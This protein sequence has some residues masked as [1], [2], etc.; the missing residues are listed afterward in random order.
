MAEAS[1]DDFI[2]N[3][4]T[5]SFSTL[6]NTDATASNEPS[7][8]EGKIKLPKI[9]WKLIMEENSENDM[10]LKSIFEKQSKDETIDESKTGMAAMYL[11]PT[12][13]K[14]D[15][16][17]MFEGGLDSMM[18]EKTNVSLKPVQPDLIDL[19]SDDDRGF[20]DENGEN[21][22]QQ[23][24]E[25]FCSGENYEAIF[26]ADEEQV[27]QDHPVLE[28]QF[29]ESEEQDDSC[30]VSKFL[31]GSTHTAASWEEWYTSSDK[32][33][34]QKAFQ[35]AVFSKS[36]PLGSLTANDLI[37]RPS[38]GK[39][40]VSP[41]V[42]RQATPLIDQPTSYKES[43]EGDD[44]ENCIKA[45]DY[46]D[47][48]DP[49][50]RPL[51]PT[52][53]DN[54]MNNSDVFNDS[55]WSEHRL[56]CNSEKVCRL[57]TESL[58]SKPSDD[59][60][61]K[62]SGDS[63]ITS[64]T[65]V[66]SNQTNEPHL[67]LEN[68]V[69]SQNL[70][71][72]V[73][74]QEDDIQKLIEILIKSKKASVERSE[75]KKIPHS[76]VE[77]IKKEIEL[78]LEKEEDRH[79]A[80]PRPSAIGLRGSMKERDKRQ[81]Q[82][83]IEHSL[84]MR[85][86]SG[87]KQMTSTPNTMKVPPT[88]SGFINANDSYRRY[89]DET[90]SS[91]L[92]VGAL[93]PDTKL[94]IGLLPPED[95]YYTPS[96]D[97]PF[98][99]QW[100]STPAVLSTP[101]NTSG[102]VFIDV[103][104]K[105][106]IFDSNVCVGM[107]ISSLISITNPTSRWLSVSLFASKITLD[108]KTLSDSE[109]PFLFKSSDTIEPGCTRD[110]RIL[111]V[112]KI[113]GLYVG[114]IR[115]EV[116]PAAKRNTTSGFATYVY[117]SAEAELPVIEVA[118]S[119][120]LNFGN[121]CWDVCENKFLTLRNYSKCDLPVKLT[122]EN[123]KHFYFAP[124]NVN[125]PTTDSYVI[126]KADNSRPDANVLH[127]FVF[128]TCSL[129]DALNQN[130]L[131]LNAI[132]SL[133]LDTPGSSLNLGRISLKA[134]VG[135]PILHTNTRSL[136]FIVFEG[137][138]EKESISRQKFRVKN[139][140]TIPIEVNT[141]SENNCFRVE[142]NDFRLNPKDECEIT[143]KFSCIGNEEENSEIKSAIVLRRK[144]GD[145]DFEI[146]AMAIVKPIPTIEANKN[147]LM[148]GRITKGE[149]KRRELI[150]KTTSQKKVDIRLSVKHQ[151]G[152]GFKV[153]STDELVL[154]P[155]K[156]E[157][158]SLSCSNQSGK[159]ENIFIE[160]GL[161]VKE[162]W[163]TNC[164]LP[165]Y[166][167]SG[168][169]ELVAPGTRFRPD[170]GF[171]MIQI[172]TIRPDGKGTCYLTLK[173]AGNMC[174]FNKILAFRDTDCQEKFEHIELENYEF[175]LLP[176][177]VK[178]IQIKLKVDEMFVVDKQSVCGV[179]CVF[180]GEE[181]AR[182][183]LKKTYGSGSHIKGDDIL[184]D[185]NFTGNFRNE[186]SCTAEKSLPSRIRI[187]SK[188]FIQDLK[189]IKFL[190]TFDLNDTQRF[191]P[192]Q[193]SH[194]VT[195]LEE[196]RMLSATIRRDSS[197]DT[198]LPPAYWETDE[199]SW[200]LEPKSISISSNKISDLGCSTVKLINSSSHTLRFD[201]NWPA[202]TINIYP[203]KGHISPKSSVALRASVVEDADI[204]TFPWTGSVFVVCN[205]ETKKFDVEI[206]E[207]S[208]TTPTQHRHDSRKAAPTNVASNS[209]L[210]VFQP[211][212]DFGRAKSGRLEELEFELQNTTT[213][214]V[215]WSLSPFAPPYSKASNSR[216]YFRVTYV[217]FQFSKVAGIAQGN[218]TCKITVQFRPLDSGLFTQTWEVKCKNRW[219]TS[220]SRVTL[221]GESFEL[222]SATAPARSVPPSSQST[223]STT[224]IQG[225]SIGPNSV[226]FCTSIGKSE[227]KKLA[228]KN[229]CK[230]SVKMTFDKPSEPFS[231]KCSNVTIRNGHFLSLPVTFSPPVA[232]E[233]TARM[234][235][236][237]E[238][239]SATL[240]L[241]GICK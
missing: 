225:V 140:G 86:N 29:L 56:S 219:K 234:V 25:K 17:S 3:A 211:M 2:G 229:R 91:K 55:K 51:T 175:C 65:S 195:A 124:S 57:S 190:I 204:T 9:D 153:E 63:K 220:V 105:E 149:L 128:C 142:P 170:N 165:L 26:D 159:L 217:V 54:H 36:E 157:E 102:P 122:I 168:S 96:P 76:T 205:K 230:K 111:F 121:L 23:S 164:F 221:K 215:E 103:I 189:R 131:Q 126:P 154:S 193:A 19:R 163:H 92:T 207:G 171:G 192:L 87:E 231:L 187:D 144:P 68:P 44:K 106:L 49:F 167:Y 31:G 53:L 123:S 166:A 178:E 22:S 10:D 186:D 161:S 100:Q 228:I 174:S 208:Q 95:S 60:T 16:S 114:E 41:P 32:I 152:S 203:G 212:V 156:G 206:V 226:D 173:N 236:Y 134:L 222:L 90:E 8:I 71:D 28:R 184:A 223:D 141:M 66:W 34:G 18:F 145:K 77:A 107:S 72:E 241:N 202:H 1:G 116:V 148:F 233:Y 227:T 93:A 180:Y 112:P 183:M 172:E 162:S 15:Q 75:K 50:K 237:C 179:L 5:S 62:D 109:V 210:L 81:E 6:D 196:A 115:I 43:N 214:I 88:P 224:V 47:E 83:L 201:A 130:P 150:L 74:D 198:E 11:Q 216:D 52:P 33:D 85:R 82:D 191:Q 155:N 70:T 35:A 61:R 89:H 213:D 133:D 73:I 232:G 125:R 218:S 24:D 118:P 235:C 42:H 117:I 99:P 197:K 113:A 46:E 138:R 177:Q 21:M 158:I 78:A 98:A 188:T 101:P 97:T 139:S 119:A 194:D 12:Y 69:T 7:L 20:F 147:S 136:R 209:S 4:D 160:G 129:V 127:I 151:S 48:V 14:A 39:E 181:F 240:Y 132:L 200:Q 169:A 238:K 137:K 58:E 176:N 143:V 37:R 182:R 146:D 239:G 199:P 59:C 84:H 30:E 45:L 104:P 110:V 185:T 120:E 79:W 27:K 80:S 38:W 13:H 67:S 108:S 94:S 135:S 40:I 64:T